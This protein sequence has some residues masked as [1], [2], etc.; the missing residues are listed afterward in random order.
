MA[1]R[2]VRTAGVRAPSD[3]GR[4]IG[5]ELLRWLAGALALAVACTGPRPDGGATAEPG[6]DAPPRTRAAFPSPAASPAA[7]VW[8]AVEN[9]RLVAEVDLAAGRVLRT[10]PVP[11][12]PHNLVAGDGVV[13]TTLQRAGTVALIR[14]GS[15]REIRLGGS[16]H[17]VKLWGDRLV[18]ANEGARR[19]EILGPRGGRLG[20]VALRG[21]PHDLAVAP[22]GRAWVSLDGSGDLALVDLAGRRVLRYVPTARRPHDLLVAPDGRVWVTDWGGDLYVLSPRGRLIRTLAVGA[23]AHHLA[24]SPDGSEAWV[25]DH[26]TRRVVVVA[27]AT[28]E[29][30][31]SLPVRGAP[32]HVAITPDGRF[33]AVADHGRGSLVVFDVARRRRVAEIPVGSGPHGAWAAPAP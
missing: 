25:T 9:S 2:R 21:N 30:V 32:H 20:G 1:G 26:G 6:A 19:L 15:A 31:A 33:A 22:G 16:P 10:V 7:A 12:K 27:T 13:A 14:G 17:D 5:V 18:V 8:V 28:L 23:E 4:V 29:V 24:F 11:G 3:F